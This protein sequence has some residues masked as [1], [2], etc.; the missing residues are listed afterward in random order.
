MGD[1]T[2]RCAFCGEKPK[3]CM[4]PIFTAKEWISPVD[5]VNTWLQSDACE[6]IRKELQNSP[7]YTKH[8]DPDGYS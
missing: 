7:M 2:R 3:D 6:D 4:E 8:D 5:D 1:N